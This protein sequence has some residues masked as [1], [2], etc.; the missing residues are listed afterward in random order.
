MKQSE[1]D[2]LS[3]LI[4]S[5]TGKNVLVIG[6]VMLDEYVW[7]KVRRISPEA[8]VPVVE[9]KERTYMAGGAGNSASNIS[10]LGGNVILCGVV[11]QDSHGELLKSKLSELGVDISGLIVDTNHPTI[12]KS[13]IIANKQHVVRVDVEDRVKLGEEVQNR[14]LEV[15]NSIISGV[16]VVVISDYGKQV[17]TERVAGKVIELATHAN[18]PVIVDP[19]GNDYRKYKEATLIT[20]NVLEAEQALN[21]EINSEEEIIHAGNRLNELIGGKAILLTRGSEGMSLFHR[22]GD[23]ITIPA[24]ARALFDVTGA[25]DTVVGT[26]AIALAAGAELKDA[27]YLANLAAGLVVEK[28]GTATVTIEELQGSLLEADRF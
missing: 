18:K 7:G 21:I 11:G 28:L 17:V 27:V 5:F 15:V 10:S 12:S 14:L 23:L 4:S 19:K 26:L 3:T 2:H 20:P 24:V 25:G 8:P 22:G 6:D 1:M 9:V 13:R 16:D